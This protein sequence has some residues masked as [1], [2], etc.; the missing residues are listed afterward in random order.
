MKKLLKAPERTIL[1]EPY[2]KNGY[3]FVKVLE[4]DTNRKYSMPYHRY[5]WEKHYDIKIPRYHEIHHKDGN[6]TN[7]DISNLQMMSKS[8]HKKLHREY[9]ARKKIVKRIAKVNR[10]IARRH[11]VHR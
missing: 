7:N 11:G 10:M 5:L 1:E 2:K 8:A 9:R 6:K 4:K 3:E